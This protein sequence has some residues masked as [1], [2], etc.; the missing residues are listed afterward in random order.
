MNIASPIRNVACTTLPF[1]ALRRESS[2][3]SKEC[4]QKSISTAAS[5][6]TSIGIIICGFI[7]NSLSLL[8]SLQG[9]FS[10]EMSIRKLTANVRAWRCGD[11]S[12]YISPNWCWV[13]IWRWEYILLL[14]VIRQLDMSLS[15]DMSIRI[16]SLSRHIVKPLVV[17]SLFFLQCINSFIAFSILLF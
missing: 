3:A 14:G 4:L 9:F 1:C 12:C 7:N 11:I 10:A 6:Q 13:K 16:Y 2:T 15:S 17:R 5:R 8:S